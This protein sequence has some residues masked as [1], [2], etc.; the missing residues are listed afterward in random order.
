MKKTLSIA[1]LLACVAFT[2][3]HAQKK[4]TSYT[5]V[6]HEEEI[7]DHHTLAYDS[8]G[9][10]SVLQG[11]VNG[12]YFIANYSY[13]GNTITVNREDLESEVTSLHQMTLD[14]QNRITSIEGPPPM[15]SFEYTRT[16][17]YDQKGYLTESTMQ[18]EEEDVWTDTFGWSKGN[19]TEA[20]VLQD[21]QG[22]ITYGKEKT[23][24]GFDFFHALNLDDYYFLPYWPLYLTGYF[25]KPTKNLIAHS[26]YVD[27]LLKDYPRI[28]TYQY[29]LDSDGYPTQ[30]DIYGE[31]EKLKT[32]IHFTYE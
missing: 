17:T 18:M 6:K 26:D 31:N 21:F 27:I 29:V 5:V 22:T 11:S 20:S 3:G 23:P 12:D 7:T 13:S 14:D 15:F 19:I 25:G 30:V 24:K 1:S 16:Y 10:L 28:Q 32:T 8:E 9:R 2:S 4:I